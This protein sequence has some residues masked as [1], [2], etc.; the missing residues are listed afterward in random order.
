[1]PHE[2]ISLNNDSTWTHC[3]G[4]LDLS[5]LPESFYTWANATVNGDLVPHLVPFLS[6]VNSFLAQNQIHHYWLTIRSSRATNEFDLPRWH[7]DRDFFGGEREK[8]QWKLCTTLIG[9]GTLFLSD[10]ARARDMQKKEREEMRRSEAGNHQ[11]QVIRCIG[12]AGMQEVVRLRLAEKFQEDRMVQAAAGECAFFRVGDESGAMH[13]EPP[14]HGD[15]VF[16]NVVPGTEVELRGLARRWGMEFPRSWSI[17]VP[18]NA[19]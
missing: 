9:P 5:S 19:I 16:V 8:V 2:S 11:C 7:T 13:S 14:S 18:L 15:R 6:F 3:G 17:G 4:L 10:G 12:C 1:M